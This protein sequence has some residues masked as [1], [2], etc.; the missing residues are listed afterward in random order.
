MRVAK[1]HVRVGGLLLAVLAGAACQTAQK[2]V[3]MLPPATA[4]AIPQAPSPASKPQ[5]GS[6]PAAPAADSATSTQEASSQ[7]A[8]PAQT[9]PPTPA[10]PASDPVADLIARVEK[11]YQAGLANYHAGNKDAAKQNFDNAFNALLESNLD[12]RSDERLQEQFDRMTEGVNG[13]DLA[14]A[15]Q[16]PDAQKSEPAPI[17]ETN[18][19]TPAADASI[20]AKAQADL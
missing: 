4:P 3:A 2:P 11:E 6:G 17:D 18:S 16:E 7:T 12:V 15:A 19:I 5:S 9:A 13:L 10:P 8:A 14:A 20:K 1:L